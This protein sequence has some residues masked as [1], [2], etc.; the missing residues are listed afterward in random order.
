MLSFF[1]LL[2]AAAVLRER[3]LIHPDI[4]SFLFISC[5]FWILNQYKFRSRNQLYLLPLIM[6]FWSNFHAEG[7]FFGIILAGAFIAGEAFTII[8]NTLKTNESIAGNIKKIAPLIFYGLAILPLFFVSPVSYKGL[9]LLFNKPGIKN[10]PEIPEFGPTLSA[11]NFHIFLIVAALFLFLLTSFR[12]VPLSLLLPAFILSVPGALTKTTAFFDILISLPAATISLN[13]LL[14]KVKN[15]IKIPAAVMVILAAFFS[16]A[17]VYIKI[18]NDPLYNFGIGIRKF[19]YPSGEVEFIK[20]SGLNVR[21]FNT[22]N[23]GGGIIFAGYPEVKA[24]VDTRVRV[25]EDTIKEIRAAENN[26]QVFQNMLEKYRINSAIVE[27]HYYYLT[28]GFFKRDA[29]ALLYW[30]DYSMLLVKRIPEF[31]DFINK[32]EI[33]V[34]NPEKLIE[35]LPLYIAK[36]FPAD[37][38]LYELQRSLAINPDCYKAHYSMAYIMRRRGEKK[39]KEILYHLTRAYDIEPHYVPALYETANLFASFNS[40]NNAIHFYKKILKEGKFHP[41][42]E[43]YPTLYREIGIVYFKSGEKRKAKK[44]FIKSLERMPE[45]KISAMYLNLAKE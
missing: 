16:T 39:P 14:N 15:I 24:F 6:P 26:P 23:L 43:L 20:K 42:I 30:S 45:D 1:I 40:Y 10:I 2:P 4:I 33:K 25:N 34:I 27:H 29:W 3:M 13:A 44:Y 21:I 31:K 19:Y 32:H 22:I 18:S 12:R 9:S 28:D 8:Y 5:Y 36:E 17:V 11:G 35:E 38:I 41:V 37:R 7:A